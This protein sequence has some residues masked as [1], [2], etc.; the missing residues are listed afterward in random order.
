MERAAVQVCTAV[1]L[2]KISTSQIRHQCAC[3]RFFTIPKE[4]ISTGKKFRKPQS[5]PI[6]SV[7]MTN[8][9]IIKHKRITVGERELYQ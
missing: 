1:D 9:G 4:R 5:L 7:Q 8:R 2:Q 6:E 3:E